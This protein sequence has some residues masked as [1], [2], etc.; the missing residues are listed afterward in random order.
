VF[1]IPGVRRLLRT[2]GPNSEFTKK[3]AIQLIGEKDL[4]SPGT[5]FNDYEDLHLD[6]PHSRREKLNPGIVF[7]HLV[8]KGLFRIGVDL[9][10]SWCHMASWTSVDALRQKLTCQMC[11]R[12]FDATRQLVDVQFSYRRSG[13]LGAERNAQGAVPTL[14]TLLQI[15]RALYWPWYRQFYTTSLDLVAKSGSTSQPSKEICHQDSVSKD[16]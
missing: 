14:L 13:V 4:S 10:C 5:S 16:A 15:S 6:E 9:T 1:K 7:G 12:E 11:G 2:H 3:S 8:E